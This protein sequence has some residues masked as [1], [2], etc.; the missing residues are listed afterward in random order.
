MN[1]YQR[2]SIDLLNEVIGKGLKECI[3]DNIQLNRNYIEYE[4]NYMIR[5]PKE[6]KE[7]RERIS[8]I[9]K[10][11]NEE[12]KA[13][14]QLAMHYGNIRELV[15]DLCQSLNIGVKGEIENFNKNNSTPQSNTKHKSNTPDD[16][17][18]IPPS[19]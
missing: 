10:N 19:E 14:N 7:I 6:R 13:I 11:F 5:N 15:C 16:K 18:Q 3:S 4:A 9:A 2:N 12:I 17:E 1:T 8:I